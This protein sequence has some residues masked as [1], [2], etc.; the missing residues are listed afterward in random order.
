MA[1]VLL[2]HPPGETQPALDI[3][4]SERNLIVL[5]SKLYTPGSKCELHN[6]DV[7]EEFAY[8]RF[9]S[10]PDELRSGS[11][12]RGGGPLGPKHPL[13][14]FVRAVVTDLLDAAVIAGADSRARS[15]ERAGSRL[16][17]AAQTRPRNCEPQASA[18]RKLVCVHETVA[19]SSHGASQGNN[20]SSREWT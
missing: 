1:R 3:A 19:L 20:A 17:A 18:M 7:P 12:A 9:R 6:R 5:L 10:G 2:C 4:L 15:V 16:A 8:A 14:E 13:A 11:P